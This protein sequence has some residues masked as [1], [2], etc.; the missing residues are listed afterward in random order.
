M[1]FF[2]EE[3]TRGSLFQEVA[4]EVDALKHGCCQG[5]CLDFH[6]LQQAFDHANCFSIHDQFF[7]A[8]AEQ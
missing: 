8:L 7:R 2:F 1:L 5:L 6:P 4:F 3:I